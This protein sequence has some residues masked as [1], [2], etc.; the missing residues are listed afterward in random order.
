MTRAA[1][2]AIPL[3]ALVACSSE[4]TTRKG[5]AETASEPASP[6]NED[7]APDTKE[8]AS[9]TQPGTDEPEPV[10]DEPEPSSCKTAPPSNA[11]GVVPQCG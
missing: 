8:P 3:L 9:A 1:L 5:F 6:A 10:P 11:C 4:T 2:F 7:E